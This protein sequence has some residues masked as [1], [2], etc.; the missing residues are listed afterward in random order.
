[1]SLSNWKC[2]TQPTL[3]NL[4]PKEYSQKFNNYS[5]AV[6][7][8]RCVGSCNTLNYFSNKVYV[9]NETEDLNLST[10]NRITRINQSKTL[11]KHISCKAKCK[12]D[13]RTCNSN[14]G[15]N[16]NKCWWE[17]NKLHVFEKDYVW[18]PATCIFVKRKDFD[19]IMDDSAIICDKS[20]K[21]YDKEMNFSGKKEPAKHKISTFSLDFY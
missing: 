8:D 19:N 12:F 11:T 15:W 2:L 14:N 6:I 5:S 3:L 16:K 7:L 17:Y 21:S 9:L 4:R 10:F 1:M 20:I 13:G 18:N